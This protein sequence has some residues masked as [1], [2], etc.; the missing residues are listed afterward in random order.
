MVSYDN[1][2]VLNIY[3]SSLMLSNIYLKLDITELFKWFYTFMLTLKLKLDYVLF[4]KITFME[5]YKANFG[6]L[7]VH[8]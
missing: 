8:A 3:L 1:R 6:E 2:V 4:V 5:K 7:C